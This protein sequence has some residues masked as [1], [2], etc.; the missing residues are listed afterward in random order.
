VVHACAGNLV[1]VAIPFTALFA[2]MAIGQKNIA[3]KSSKAELL[4][5]ERK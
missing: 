4:Q 1:A 2:P 5:R 3:G